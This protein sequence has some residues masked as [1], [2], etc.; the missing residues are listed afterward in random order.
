M[1]ELLKR[2]AQKTPQAGQNI[3]N[4]GLLMAGVTGATEAIPATALTV[5]PEAP[6]WLHLAQL[7][8]YAVSAFLVAK[9]QAQTTE[10][11]NEKDNGNT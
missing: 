3:R 1:K 6:E 8:L 4:I 9:G 10:T 2:F 7:V 11:T 5:H